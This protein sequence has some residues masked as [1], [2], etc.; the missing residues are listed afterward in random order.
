MRGEFCIAQVLHWIPQLRARICARLGLDV[1]VRGG[2]EPGRLQAYFR[3]PDRMQDLAWSL[4]CRP[5]QVFLVLR[6]WLAEQMGIKPRLRLVRSLGPKDIGLFFQ[7]GFLARLAVILECPPYWGDVA[8]QL[9]DQSAML[10]LLYQAGIALPGEG[11]SLEGLFGRMV[12]AVGIR[13][14][15]GYYGRL[16]DIWNELLDLVRE[17]AMERLCARLGCAP[18]DLFATLAG[19]VESEELDDGDRFVEDGTQ[20]LDMLGIA[21]LKERFRV[22]AEVYLN[23]AR[24]VAKR[25]AGPHA[26]ADGLHMVGPLLDYQARQ[27]YAEALCAIQP[28]T[29]TVGSLTR[30]EDVQPIAP[31]QPSEP[32]TELRARSDHESDRPHV[33]VEFQHPADPPWRPLLRLYGLSP[34]REKHMTNHL[35]HAWRTTHGAGDTLTQQVLTCPLPPLIT[36]EWEAWELLTKRDH[37]LIRYFVLSG[38]QLPDDYQV[39]DFFKASH[40]LPTADPAVRTICPRPE[41]TEERLRREQGT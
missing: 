1:S 36:P 32:G 21:C 4:H 39:R 35:S 6:N 37:A 5:D 17:E 8:Q 30:P 27:A 26:S 23:E 33:V 20:R 25:L 38:G 11:T 28:P 19:Q 22:L 41:E 18:E 13:K 2:E 14:L 9:F 29:P 34:E 7:E 24:E 10:H 12:S 16:V 3:G 15:E 40:K 31:L